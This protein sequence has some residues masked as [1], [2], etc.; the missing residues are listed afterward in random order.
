MRSIREALYQC[1]IIPVVVIDDASHAKRLG[2]A[3]LNGGLRAAEVTF[4]T[5]AAEKTIRIL[6]DNYPELLVGAGTVLTTEQA[7][8]AIGAGSDFIVSPGL[9]PRVTAHVLDRNVPM[10]PGV[11]TPSEIEAALEFGLSELKFFPA[12]PSGGLKMIEALA[13]PY[14]NVRFMPTGGI[15]ETNVKEYLESNRILACGGSWM[16]K[17]SLIAEEN[18]AEIEMRACAAAEIVRAIRG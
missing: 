2:E 8:R 9:N 18:F 10:I 13:A 4:R 6:K 5:E 17:A 14:G 11:L 7:D 15:N 12:E 1:G 16:V 3:L